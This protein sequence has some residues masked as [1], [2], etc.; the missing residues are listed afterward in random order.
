MGRN[1]MNHMEHL[2]SVALS[3]CAVL[4]TKEGTYK[5]SWKRAGGGSAWFMARRNLDRLI[6]MMAPK[7]YPEHVQTPDNVLATLAALDHIVHYNG[8]GGRELPG[9]IEATRQI[10]EMLGDRFT[11]EDIFMKIRQA[12]GGEDGTVLACL[13]DARR[14]FMLVEAEMIAEGVVQLESKTYEQ[15]TMFTIHEW[16]GQEIGDIEVYFNGAL[17]SNVTACTVSAENGVRRVDITTP[18][19]TVDDAAVSRALNSMDPGP[20][21]GDVSNGGY[22]AEQA[23][24]H[25]TAWHD[26][27]GALLRRGDTCTWEQPHNRGI[28]EVEFVGVVDD[29]PLV[30]INAEGDTQVTE[31]KRLRRDHVRSTQHGGEEQNHA[32]SNP[33]WPW[34]ATESDYQAMH[35]RVGAVTD[36]FYTRRAAGVY[37][38]EGIVGAH[39]CP[40]ELIACYNLVSTDDGPRKWVLRR[41][42]VPVEIKD[43]YRDLQR[44]VNDKEH[45]GMSTDFKFMYNWHESSLKWIID[46]KFDAWVRD[47]G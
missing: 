38:L 28:V 12:P 26:K 31:W 43:N 36:M 6:T 40:A 25:Q 8:N 45:E 22:A 13:R 27:I 30:K 46:P 17:L 19:L 18:P 9:S 41:D 10:L 2:E 44:E 42:K 37:Q 24:R 39:N 20:A 34:H 14:Y 11:A 21:I 29:Q 4:Q 47:V 1:D 7:D 23:A 15:E 16:D 5:G 32:K 3:D 35:K 33:L